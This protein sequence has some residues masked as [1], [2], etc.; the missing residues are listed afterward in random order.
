[1]P[2]EERLEIAAS[3]LGRLGLSGHEYDYPHALSG[4]M[5][6]RVSIARAFAGK[7]GILLCDEPFSALDEHTGNALR[8]EFRDLL[9]QTGATSIFITH[10]IDEALWLG[11]RLMVFERPARIAYEAALA[12]MGE[13]ERKAVRARIRDVLS[14]GAAAGGTAAKNSGVSS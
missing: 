1:M 7:P 11:G 9:R 2:E 13:E 6:Q 14:G 3:W 8:E 4:G 5:R 10:S 12:G